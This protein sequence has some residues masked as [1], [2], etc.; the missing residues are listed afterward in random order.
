[1]NRIALAFAAGSFFA[2]SACNAFEGS[3]QKQFECQDEL[4]QSLEDDFVQVCS[5][6][7]DGLNQALRANAE[8]ECTD[9]ANA[10]VAL[11]ACLSLLD[12][13]TLKKSVDGED[14]PCAAVRETVT[15]ALT[16]TNGGA[17]CDGIADDQPG[18]GEEAE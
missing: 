8:K 13:E 16:A 4:G 9:L 6:T 3:C 11:A 18:E 10:Q 7:N 12:C 2:L 17:D 5:K 15:D 14:D 1:M